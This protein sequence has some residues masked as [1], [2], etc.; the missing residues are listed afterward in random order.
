[1]KKRNLIIAA[2]AVFLISAAFVSSM[3][4]QAIMAEASEGTVTDMTT[5]SAYHDLCLL[6]HDGDFKDYYP[7]LDDS[8]VR[9]DSRFSQYQ[10][11]CSRPYGEDLYT[12]WYFH[13][14]PSDSPDRVYD[15]SYDSKAT[16][17]IRCYFEIAASKNNVK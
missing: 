11:I 3:A 14:L 12:Y 17:Q 1:M 4:D 5:S 8:I 16:Y 6:Y 9:A 2:S 15:I 10:M 13:D 7:F